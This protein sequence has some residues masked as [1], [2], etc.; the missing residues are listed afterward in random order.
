[1]NVLTELWVGM[2]FGTYSA[3]RGWSADQLA[4]A[5]ARLRADGLLDGDELSDRGREWRD[6]LEATTDAHGGRHRRGLGPGFDDVVA[7]L[8]EWSRRCIAAAAF[9]PDVFKR[10]AG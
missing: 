6:G 8:D 3:T 10:A 2:P 1:M 7:R 5:A 4:T 9:P